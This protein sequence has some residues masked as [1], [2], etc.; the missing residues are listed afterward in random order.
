MRLLV[1]LLVVALLLASVW[2]IVEARRT[3]AAERWRVQIDTAADGALEVAVV[4]DRGGR[5]VVRSLP[6]SAEGVD[7]T[8][9][10]RLA[11]E[12][13]ESLAAELNDRRL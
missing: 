12:D 3:A 4:S 5:R 7:L 10:L 8:A 13:A 11:R 9:D 2:L 6:A 1:L